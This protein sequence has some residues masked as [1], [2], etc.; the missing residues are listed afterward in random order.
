[1]SI[2]FN[3]V[4]CW[5]QLFPLRQSISNIFSE[6]SSEMINIENEIK[7]KEFEHRNYLIKLL[8]LKDQIVVLILF[9]SLAKFNQH[10]HFIIFRI[11]I[12]KQ[13]PI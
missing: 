13:K 6:N 4:N 5:F 3:F 10:Y 11:K 9:R 1:M 12:L 7:L 2:L 8:L